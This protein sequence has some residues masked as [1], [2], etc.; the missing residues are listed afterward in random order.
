PTRQQA[1][2]RRLTASASSCVTSLRLFTFTNSSR[3]L[4]ICGDL[5]IVKTVEPCDEKVWATVRSRPLIIVTTAITAVT[6]TIIPI[7][8]SAVRSLLV[9]RLEV[10]TRK[11]SQIAVRRNRPSQRDFCREAFCRLTPKGRDEVDG[12]S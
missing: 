7:N 2:Q 1:V 8:V 10:A 5:E 12:T 4:M 9:R 3:D 11:A 6:P